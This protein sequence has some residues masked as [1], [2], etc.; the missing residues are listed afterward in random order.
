MNSAGDLVAALDIY[1]IGDDVTLQIRR[2]SSGSNPGRIL[3]LALTLQEE[4][5]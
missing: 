1:D 2:D 3:S 4:V 5:S